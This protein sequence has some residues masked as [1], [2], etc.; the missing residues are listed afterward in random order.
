MI[1]Q[2][3]DQLI[4]QTPLFHFQYNENDVY[5]KL[6]KYNPAQ[7]IKDR[8]VLYMLK[9]AIEQ[10]Q[11]QKDTVLIEATSGNTGIA[12]AML[13]QAYQIPVE[14]VMPESMSL[15]RRQLIQAYGATLLLTSA[16]DGMQGAMDYM[17]Q[18]LKENKN[19]LSLQQ[20]NNPANL[21]AHYETT[22]K[23]ILEDVA[24]DI[25]V[26]G[27]GTGGTITG[28]AKYFKD[29]QLDTMIIG[30]EPASSPLLTQG[31]SGK[32]R[33][34]GIGANF[35]PNILDTTLLDDVLPVSDDIAIQTA[36]NFAKQTGILIG[37]SS[38]ANLA[39]ALE[40]AKQTKG[41]KIVTIAP[42]GFEK[43]LTDYSL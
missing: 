41:K 25:F 8:A 38:G 6:E 9:D 32:H 39:I 3:V 43:Y 42:D 2:S 1:I 30:V 16:K 35:I 24:P 11:I 13:A 7:S 33:I 12:L 36:K 15:E 17:N 23:E 26:A 21:Q 4:G 20:F 22:A 10:N 18:K 37:I 31:Y 27:I 28:I 19:Y 14:I 29:K 40:L 5:I 34:Q